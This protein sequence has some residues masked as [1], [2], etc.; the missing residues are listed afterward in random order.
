MEGTDRKKQTP[1]PAATSMHLYQEILCFSY[2][3]RDSPTTA[4]TRHIAGRMECRIHIAR[5]PRVAA[6]WR[7]GGGGGRRRGR[8]GL[9]PPPSSRR[10]VAVGARVRPPIPGRGGRRE[11][12]TASTYLPAPPTHPRRSPPPPPGRPPRINSF[13]V[14]ASSL[15][16]PP[17]SSS[18][19]PVSFVEECADHVV[20]V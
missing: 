10:P 20:D 11:A 14:I 2:Y 9:L 5:N 15:P 6:S 1:P 8:G 18:S 7:A 3:Y 4:R 19:P 13:L 16:Q 17:S 12:P